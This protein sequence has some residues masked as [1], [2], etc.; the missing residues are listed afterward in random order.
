MPSRARHLEI[1]REVLGEEF[2]AVHDELDENGL[3]FPFHRLSHNPWTVRRI[4]EERGEKAAKAAELHIRADFNP[5]EMVVDLLR[6]PP[7]SWPRR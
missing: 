3:P 4:R 2:P 5:L 1:D 7:V 6:H